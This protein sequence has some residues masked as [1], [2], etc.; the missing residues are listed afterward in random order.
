[1]AVT[2]TKAY[3]RM[4]QRS[5]ISPPLSIRSTLESSPLTSSQTIL[6]HHNYNAVHPRLRYP[7]GLRW[8]A[9]PQ[10]ASRCGR[11]PVLSFLAAASAL[12]SPIP[13]EHNIAA[14]QPEIPGSV[15][16]LIRE[17]ETVVA[18]EP[19]PDCQPRECV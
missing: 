9:S 16:I 11:L 3:L 1:M 13:A 10:L 7:L 15:D 4:G 8:V 12:A 6:H 2:T 19:S 17:P 14:R 5:P 18:R